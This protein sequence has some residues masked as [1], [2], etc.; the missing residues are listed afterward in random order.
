MADDE[1]VVPPDQAA[2]TGRTGA[3]PP[4]LGGGQS[5][6]SNVAAM[7]NPP[8]PPML[9][10]MPAAGL[11][12][13]MQTLSGQQAPQANP[14]L[15]MSAGV[16]QA[17]AGKTGNPYLEGQ[18]KAF[19]HQQEQ[20]QGQVSFLL[21][22][23]DQRAER[24]W[25]MNES[26]LSIANDALKN[27]S[28]EVREWGARSKAEVMRKMGLPQSAEVINGFATK[29]ITED[30]VKSAARYLD[31]FKDPRKA[32]ELSGVP[33]TTV[34]EIQ[35]N[36]GSD[37]YS[38]IV[39][40]K[41]RAELKQE[42]INLQKSEIELW[43][44]RNPLDQG[45]KVAAAQI[46]LDKFGKTLDELPDAD[47]ANVVR[48]AKDQ[49]KAEE[50]AK[51][52]RDLDDQLQLAQV[53]AN[54]AQSG[55]SI[56]NKSV[57]ELPGHK[58]SLIDKNGNTYAGAQTDSV[59]A[60]IKQGFELVPDKKAA[61]IQD[62]KYAF[63]IMGNMRAQAAYLA[64]TNK[65]VAAGAAFQRAAEA[66]PD[67]AAARAGDPGAIERLMGSV[68]YTIG[69]FT[70]DPDILLWAGMESE[71][72]I[73]LR[74]LGDTNRAIQAFHGA[75]NIMKTGQYAAIDGYIRNLE[76]GA[77]GQFDARYKG[78][79]KTTYIVKDKKTGKSG[80]LVLD[81]GEA[82]DLNRYQVM[83]EFNMPPRP[84]E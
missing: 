62:G 53:R 4:P 26:A 35:K 59:G 7:L 14:W 66:S 9:N 29:T 1:K 11:S 63:K 6:P 34:Q 33:L 20:Q 15:A 46:A 67:Y 44:K 65:M 22:L 31:L 23:Q 36:Q 73:T 49:I 17:L 19:E 37:A 21:K 51:H 25:K 79:F 5:L 77:L 38:R 50:D 82:L 8:A 80:R 3:P 72:I 69:N 45:T 28:P 76:T 41:S 30:Q 64:Q 68:R 84:S 56:E 60:A 47:R 54:T 39:L 27:D 32:A 83:P 43:E 55:R 78:A 10:P 70:K 16:G 42:G 71:M 57:A 12:G 58:L 61:Q 74:K 13:L 52:K 2:A 81:P 48:R 24:E 18:Q 40:G 75:M